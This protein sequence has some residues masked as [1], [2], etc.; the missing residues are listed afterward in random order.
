VPYSP[1][2]LER[3]QPSLWQISL[4]PDNSH[5]NNLHYN[6]SLQVRK[7]VYLILACTVPLRLTLL[8]IYIW[9]MYG[10][11]TPK[12]QLMSIIT[13]TQ[14]T[15]EEV[16]R[17]HLRVRPRAGCGNKPVFVSEVKNLLEHLSSESILQNVIYTLMPQKS[18]TR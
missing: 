13:F 6:L 10:G 14:T 4:K 18:E 1:S 17:G 3:R 9:N 7:Y 16:S 5:K 8:T 11:L 15:C 12:D 2:V